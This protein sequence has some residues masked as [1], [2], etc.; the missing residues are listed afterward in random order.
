M[1]HRNLLRY[2]RLPQLL[3]FATVQP[4]VFLLL[5]TYVFGGAI[6]VGGLDYVDYLVPGII[7]QTVL[8]GATNTGLALADDLSRGMV[9]RFRSLPMAR[10]AV[11]AG[12]TFADMVRNVFAVGSMIGVGY[13][14]GFNFQNGASAA[15]LAVIITLMLGFAFCWI[16]AFLGLL[17]RDAETAQVAGF[18][19]VF[20]LIFASSMFVPIATMPDW[21]EAFA[22]ISP[23]T[24]TVD[25][26]RALSLGGEVA[27]SLWKCLAWI[28]GI[29]MVFGSLSVNKYR[30]LA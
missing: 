28:A 11:L 4:V 17:V 9:D 7:I 13:L 3:V 26:V 30:H 27:S 8:F 15:L 18:V 14:I 16:T 10:S 20:P 22:K 29:L 24:A 25:T 21:L 23:V 12:R 2:V 5:F 6:N 1:T 19:T